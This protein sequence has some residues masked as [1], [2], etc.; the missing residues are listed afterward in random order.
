MLL[1][2]VM[3]GRISDNLDAELKRIHPAGERLILPQVGMAWLAH[4]FGQ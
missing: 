4:F 1:A 3:N 2:L